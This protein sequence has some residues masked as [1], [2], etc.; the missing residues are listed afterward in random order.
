MCHFAFLAISIA[1]FGLAPAAST[2]A[3]AARARRHDTGRCSPAIRSSTRST[4]IALTLVGC[5]SG[6]SPPRISHGAGDLRAGGHSVLTEKCL[7][8]SI[9]RL[10]ARINVV[11]QP[12]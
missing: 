12:D 7:T 5:V 8:L 4:I 11:R 6:I 2:R 1:L 3:E 9:S 10:A